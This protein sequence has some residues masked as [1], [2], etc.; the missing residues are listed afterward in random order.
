MEE[1]KQLFDLISGNADPDQ[2]KEI[3]AGIK[4]DAQLRKEYER[5]KNAL[6]LASSEKE[7]DKMQ[8]EHSWLRFKREKRANMK[9]VLS[10]VLKYAAIAL[11][12]LSMGIYT[13]HRM[14]VGRSPFAAEGTNEIH[15]PN[16]EK[17]EIVLSDGS[18]IWLNAGTTFRFPQT[19]QGTERKVSLSG[20]AF[21]EVKSGT[22]PFVVSSSYGDIEVRGTSFNLRAYPDMLFQATLVEGRISFKSD[23]TERSLIP[24]QQ[25]TLNR[26]RN[27]EVQQVDTKYASS[28]R[29]GVISFEHEPLGDVVRRLERHFNIRIELD[30]RLRPIHFTGQLFNESVEEL[31]EYINKTKPITYA[32]DKKQ[33]KLTITAGN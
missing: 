20:E 2:R 24:G 13:G 23:G 10:Q 1:E 4:N 8:I 3:L 7:M 6:A 31:M 16:G 12:L 14:N 32:Y 25:L 15:V 22:M 21:F 26:D 9:V 5:I 28:W 19:F 17:A 33:G 30:Q 18:K 29:E 27:I 11:L